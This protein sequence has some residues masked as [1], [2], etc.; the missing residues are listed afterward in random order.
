MYI[1]SCI[2]I[3]YGKLLAGALPPSS[4]SALPSRR[5]ILVSC[6]LMETLMKQDMV[7]LWRYVHTY[8]HMYTYICAYRHMK[9]RERRKGDTGEEGEQYLNHKQLENGEKGE[10]DRNDISI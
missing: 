9:R 6:K 2:L 10:H 3:H 7:P 1:F 5:V 8:I 4:N